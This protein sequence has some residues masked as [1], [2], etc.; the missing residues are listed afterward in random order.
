M[1]ATSVAPSHRAPAR[2][3]SIDFRHAGPY[4]RGAFLAGFHARFGHDARYNPA[5]LPALQALLGEIERDTGINDVRQAAYL[6]ATVLWETTSPVRVPHQVRNRRGQPVLDRHRQPVVVM[7]R[8]WL[9]TMAPV[10]EIG[11]GRGRRYHE[12]VKVKT[13]PDGSVRITEQD[14]DQFSVAV[15]G[16]VR[17][18]ARGAVMGSPSGAA[19]SPVYERD[20]GAEN[21]YFGRGFVQLTWW[22]NY[23]AAGVAL[24]RGLELLLQPDLLKTREVAY[25]VMSH[26]MR[27]GQGFANGH[28]FADYF[29]GPRTDYVGARRMV[30][31]TDHAFDIAAIARR[32]EQ[33]LLGARPR[34]AAVSGA[35][36][37][38]AVHP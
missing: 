32:F 18:L 33:V 5:A 7:E 36:P 34:V 1:P 27:T 12:P 19:A 35:A 25:A 26:G 28:R 9:I 37:A 17:P 8:R 30:N 14:G 31:G 11:E 3:P 2:A 15:D 22:S 16:R 6:L 38:A 4:D 10:S 29:A 21:A 24:G 20:D 13:L 23:A